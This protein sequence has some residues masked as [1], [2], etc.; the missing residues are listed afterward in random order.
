MKSLWQ[1]LCCFS[2]VIVVV[3]LIPQST[4]GRDHD[5]FL[6]SV[7][8]IIDPYIEANWFTGTVALY[9]SD[10]I[11]YQRSHGYADIASGQPI[12]A[13]TKIRIGSITKHYTAALVLRLIQRGVF[14]LDDPLAKFDLGFPNEIAQKITVRHLLS[15]RSGFEDLFTEEYI[16][17][18]QSLKTIDDKL[19]LIMNQPL[20]FEPGTDHSYSNYGYIVLGAIVERTTGKSFKQVLE[21]EILRPIGAHHTDYAL[22]DE[23]KDKALSYTYTWAGR[24]QDVTHRLEN[25]TPDGGMYASASDLVKFYS[26]LYYSD[27]LINDRMKAIMMSGYAD[28]ARPWS[29]I[30]SDPKSLRLAYGGGPGVSAAVEL[31]LRD[32][33]FVVVLANT[34]ALVA[35]KISQRITDAFRGDDPPPMQLPMSVFAYGYLRE[36]GDAAFLSEIESTL[37]TEGY[38]GF[39]DRPFNRLG[40]EL[41]RLGEEDE[42]ITVLKAN[43]ALFPD[44]ANTFDSLAYA[45]A[46][47]GQ[48]DLAIKYYE[49]AL[50][51]DPT[52]ESARQGLRELTQKN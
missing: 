31:H 5:E 7:D 8:R 34:D 15:H 29:E 2:L 23:V 28:T 46:E 37:R 21:A 39:S 19:P 49:Q 12:T 18:Y 4:F 50:R 20:R 17:H 6:A 44:R 38:E 41:L 40:L 3:L 48:T 11:I 22:T 45:Y 35:E 26:A 36:V 52:F 51:V 33:F 43:C 13:D 9:Q 10:R 47:T 25:L 42:A 27:T 16:N 32:R 30:A 24:K 1:E 14:E